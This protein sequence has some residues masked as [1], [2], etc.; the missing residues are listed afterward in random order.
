MTV[1]NLFFCNIQQ[2]LKKKT[3]EE[4]DNEVEKTKQKELK[5]GK[6]MNI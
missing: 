3:K 6:T 1:R 4:K 5:D 2:V